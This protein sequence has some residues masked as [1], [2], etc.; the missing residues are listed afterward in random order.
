[1]IL[2]GHLGDGNLHVNI[3][4]NDKNSNKP[5]IEKNIYSMVIRLG[6]TISAEHGIG[7]TKIKKHMQ[8]GDH[9]KIALI[10]NLKKHFDPNSILNPGK[11]VK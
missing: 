3:L 4:N 2:F 9:K 1:M 10:K 6:G 5:L 8:H 7:V 11:L